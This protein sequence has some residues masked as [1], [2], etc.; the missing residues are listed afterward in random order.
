MREEQAAVRVHQPPLA[1]VLLR[2]EKS[3]GVELRSLRPAAIPVPILR[4]GLCGEFL[5][6]GL[7]ALSQFRQRMG[8]SG[9]VLV[10]ELAEG[11]N[12]RKERGGIPGPR[13]RGCVG[14]GGA[15]VVHLENAGLFRPVHEEQDLGDIRGI[16][17]TRTAGGH[18]IAPHAKQLAAQRIIAGAPQGDLQRAALAGAERECAVDTVPRAIGSR[19]VNAAIQGAA[20]G[21]CVFHF[22]RHLSEG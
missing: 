18:R 21:A 9:P 11:V 3:A 7:P 13:G 2:A 17:G 14:A 20:G 5:G 4:A 6:L 1:V 15:D 19:V 10:L 12:E 16:D 22:H 8:F